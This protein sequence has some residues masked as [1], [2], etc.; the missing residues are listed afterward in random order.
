MLEI[1]ARKFERL[2]NKV[3]E[4][5][6]TWDDLKKLHDDLEALGDRDL[7]F[8]VH[9]AFGK[10]FGEGRIVVH[11]GDQIIRTGK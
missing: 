2:F 8:R 9:L 4:M 6:T 7:S 3:C 11:N 10:A 5:H 1:Q